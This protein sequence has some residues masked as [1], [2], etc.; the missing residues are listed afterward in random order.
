MLAACFM[1]LLLRDQD[2]MLGVSKLC[3]KQSNQVRPFRDA[4]ANPRR[5]SRLPGTKRKPDNDNKWL[6]FLWFG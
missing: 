4:R 6:M 1:L 2:K 3:A 5:L